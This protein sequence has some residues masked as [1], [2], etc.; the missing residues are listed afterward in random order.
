MSQTPKPEPPPAWVDPPDVRATRE[1]MRALW[2][3]LDQLVA[4]R[5]ALTEKP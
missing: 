4:A 5:I 3:R 1:R 2:E